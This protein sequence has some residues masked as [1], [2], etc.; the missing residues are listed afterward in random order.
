[1][2]SPVPTSSSESTD[3][4]YLAN[5]ALGW[6]VV[7]F[8]FAAS[9]FGA[10][11][12]LVTLDA[13]VTRGW[14]GLWDIAIPSLLSCVAISFFLARR[15]AGWCRAR[16]TDDASGNGPLSMAQAVGLAY[17]PL[18]RWGLAT[19][20]VMAS[21]TFMAAQLVAVGQVAHTL[22][23]WPFVV[24]VSGFGLA[25]L[26]YS[27]LGGYRAV[28]VTDVVQ[29]VLVAVGLAIPLAWFGLFGQA[30]AWVTLSTVP[31]ANGASIA[32]T[33]AQWGTVLTFVIGWMV[34]PEMWQRMQSLRLG[35]DARLA[36]LWGAGLLLG[37]FGLI[38]ALAWLASG[39]GYS[40][41]TATHGSAG[42]VW[43]QLAH[44]V[45]SP[46]WQAVMVI[47]VVCAIASTMDSTLNVGS[48]V[49]SHD[50]MPARWQSVGPLVLSRLAM[51]VMLIGAWVV[52]VRFQDVLH[53][54]WLSADF[55]ASV[56]ALPVVVMLYQPKHQLPSNAVASAARWAMGT[57]A[58]ITLLLRFSPLLWPATGVML[59][60]W[61][62]TT[63]WAVASSAVVFIVVWQIKLRA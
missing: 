27:V 35:Q 26:V 58:A 24:T 4:F 52:A 16:M 28:V 19:I 42:V 62:W 46:V 25:V 9:W 39:L 22:L 18:G 40:A 38:I 51:V 37:L 44:W 49:L 2:S 53:I 23:A 15:V 55:Y 6:V 45:A 12:T 31:L 3:Q 41:T 30:H 50:V 21:T 57:G 60:T 61:P 5:R 59:P 34:A 56:V 47:G 17:G 32:P 1:M 7:G 13:L 11:S 8:T 36:A 54:L 29:L 14:N 63:L 20:I 43:G 10:S 33:T 48:M